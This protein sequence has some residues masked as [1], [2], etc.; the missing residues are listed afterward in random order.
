MKTPCLSTGL[1]FRTGK[2]PPATNPQHITDACYLPN[3]VA[4]SLSVVVQTT[5][6][7]GSGSFQYTALSPQRQYSTYKRS[8]RTLHRQPQQSPLPPIP[9]P[10]GKQPWPTSKRG[11]KQLSIWTRKRSA[12]IIHPQDLLV[13]RLPQEELPQLQQW[14]TIPSFPSS[15]TAL[16]PY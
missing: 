15:V 11:M 1:E 10:A 9:T 14:P 6:C 12:A 4:G 2:K 5:A 8:L 3:T 13:P 16:P 7:P